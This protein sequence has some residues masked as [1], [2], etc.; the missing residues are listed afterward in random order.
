VGIDTDM[1]MNVLIKYET[2]LWTLIG[3]AVGFAISWFYSAFLHR[4]EYRQRV[5][6]AI[7]RIKGG[8][9]IE[10]SQ[11]GS[12]RISDLLPQFREQEQIKI[13]G[14]VGLE[15]SMNATTDQVTDYILDEFRW[16]CVLY[17]LFHQH[18]HVK[19][20]RQDARRVGSIQSWLGEIGANAVEY[21]QS[22]RLLRKVFDLTNILHTYAIEQ[23]YPDVVSAQISMYGHIGKLS[24]GIMYG[25]TGYK[26]LDFKYGI[27]E[28]L[29]QI[30]DVRKQLKGSTLPRNVR[31]KLVVECEAVAGSIKKEPSQGSV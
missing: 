19:R 12:Q 26:A 21:R 1:L 13:L 14:E 10:G 8:M 9:H 15:S 27:Q 7:E 5:T 11:L 3:V 24:V 31:N 28:A 22:E 18:Q 17:E 29:G 2:P 16:H 6:H 30:A 20:S 25:V 4:R 23:R